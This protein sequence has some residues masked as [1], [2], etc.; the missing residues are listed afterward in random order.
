MTDRKIAA[1]AGGAQSPVEPPLPIVVVGHVDHGKSTLVGRL[2][3]DT[4]S[5][6]NGKLEELRALARRRGTELEWSFVLDALQVERDQGITVDTTRLW[7][8]SAR[9]G[10]VI[11]DAPGHAEFLRNMVT[12]AASA[13]AA[14]LVVDAT[15]GVSEQT[16]RHAY[17]LTLLSVTQ[18]AVVVNKM[19]LLGHDRD[20]FEAVAGEVRR[21]LG[22]IGLVPSAVIPIAA[23]HGDNVARRSAAMDW[24]DGPTLLD[25]LDGFER[26]AAP[27]DQPLRL[28][29]QDVYRQDDRR[30]LVGRIESGRLR[31]GDTL[32]FAPGGQTARLVSIETWNSA[33]HISAGA[34]QSVALVLDREIFVE[35]GAVASH[36]HDRPPEV[37]RLQVRLFWLDREPLVPGERLTLRLGTAR[38]AVTVEAIERVI[39]VQDLR[40]GAADR[41]EP[42]GVAEVVLRA[43]A[44]IAADPFTAVPATGRGVLV[45]DH[46]VV[47]GAVVMAPLA[48]DARNLTPVASS[49]SAAERAAANGHRGGVYWFT[50]LSGAGKSTLAMA[51]QRHLFDRGYQVYVLD[52]DNLRQGLNRNLGFS[53]EDRSENIRRVAEVARL[54]ADAGIIVLTAFISPYRADRASA[55]EIIGE[56]FREVYVKASLDTCAARDPKGLYARARAGEIPEFTGVTAPYEEPESPDLVLDTER[57]A[58]EAAVALL[59]EDVQHRF[60]VRGGMIGS[61]QG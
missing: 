12:G 55:R 11:I 29:I 1:A 46:R 6:P 38:H 47:G 58:V 25:A 41:V 61:R 53:P 30:I 45:R 13:E 10:Y 22:E 8:R 24:W 31:V 23:R 35:R 3:H 56:D 5:L 50:G 42:N 15:Q 43:R 59:Y 40:A 48:A 2:L 49:V 36:V 26:R 37:N 32:R 52:G 54:F 16:R 28:P 4:D 44:R 39:D 9:R 18:V 14:V 27:V 57:L 21:Y 19:D 33:P 17:L 51:F 7:F 20:R 60:A 34:G